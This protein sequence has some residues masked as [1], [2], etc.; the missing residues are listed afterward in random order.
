MKRTITFVVL[1]LLGSIRVSGQDIPQGKREL[2]V[3]APAYGGVRASSPIADANRIQNEGGSDGAGLCV[4]ASLVQNGQ[5][6][7]VPMCQGGKDSALWRYA[8]SRPGGYSPGKLEAA[9]D[10]I[11][12][13]EKWFSYLGTDLNVLRSVL[14]MGYPVGITYSWGDVYGRRIH[15]MVSGEND[16]SGYAMVA[17]NNRSAPPFVNTPKHTVMTQAE[18]EA[19]AFDGGQ[20]W[21]FGWTRKPAVVE[22]LSVSPRIVSAMVIFWGGLLSVV[23]ALTHA[24]SVADAGAFAHK[25]YKAVNARRI[26]VTS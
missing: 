2:E 12:P 13:D 24:K 9:L 6:Q 26:G 8:K 14:A 3:D 23:Q 22:G 19:R 16:T 10:A 4:I 11:D 7:G 20:Y 15:H 25:T 1:T 17:D 18:F 5:Q 21:L